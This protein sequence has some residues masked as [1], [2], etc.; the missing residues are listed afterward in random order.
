MHGGFQDQTWVKLNLAREDMHVFCP[1]NA[2]LV[3]GMIVDFAKLTH[4]DLG[5]V[6]VLFASLRSLE[7]SGES[8]KKNT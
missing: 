1:T 5:G 6:V 3:W 7:E 2:P 4:T 8:E